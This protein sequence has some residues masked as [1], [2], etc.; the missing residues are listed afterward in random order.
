MKLLF[1]NGSRGEWGYIRPIIRRCEQLGIDYS[2]CATNMLMLPGYGMLVDEIKQDGFKVEDEIYMSLEGSN[3]YTMV[4]SLGIFLISFVDVLYRQRPDWIILAGDRGEQ[5]MG[6]VAGAYTYT[7]VAHIQA[8]ERS[9]NIDGTAR[10]AIGKFAHLHLAANADAVERLLKLG[11]EPF[12]VHN[13][14]APQLDE[15]NEGLISTMADLR[16]SYHIEESEPYLLV[17]QHPV[18][19]EMD[20]AEEQVKVLVHALN[21]FQMRKIWILPNNDAG[22]ETTRRVLLQERRS[23]SYIYENLTRKDYLG[24]LKHCRAIVGNSSSGLLEAPTFGIPA[25]NIGRRQ[26]DRVQGKNVIN[27]SFELEPCVAAIEKAISPTFRESLLD[28]SNPYGDGQS[29]QRILEVLY[30]TFVDNRLLVKNLM[31]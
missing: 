21:R 11:E 8:G 13:V 1:I 26:N 15:L 12:R 2:I 3:H 25:V 28:C 6:S 31:Y 19:E 18:T 30:N 20:R 10:H 23:D 14:G 4:K 9:G 5:L 17:A 7:P 24:L 22:S 29:A 27:V 16:R